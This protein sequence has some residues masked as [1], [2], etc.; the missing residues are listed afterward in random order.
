MHILEVHQ[1]AKQFGDFKAVK[2]IDFHVEQGEVFGFLGPNGA[3]KTT[4]INMLTGLARPSSGTIRIA[5]HD[6][7]KGIKKVQ[8]LIGIVPDESNL[9]EDMSGYENL[10]FCASLYGMKKEL[11]E[12]RARELYETS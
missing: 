4:T 3:G 12:K 7:I 1:L 11:R 5:R 9:Y 10:T 8:K 6:G 2:G